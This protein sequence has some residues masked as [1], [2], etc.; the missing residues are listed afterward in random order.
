VT[1]LF[2]SILASG[3]IPSSY[4]RATIIPLPKP[5]S[6]EFRPISLL[7]HLSKVLEKIVLAKW[8]RPYVACNIKHDQFAFTSLNGTGCPN[9]L[10]V[11]Y[12]AALQST[13][14]PGDS[15]RILAID[16]VKAFDRAASQ[17]LM[18]ALVRLG[19]PQECYLWIRNF[20]QHR[21]QRVR[22]NNSF[23]A[24]LPVRSGVPQGS[25]T[26]P[27]LFAALIDS[28]SPCLSKTTCIKYADDVTMVHHIPKGEIDQ[29]DQEW[30]AVIAWAEQHD[31]EI[32]TKKTKVMTISFSKTLL[33]QLASLQG[34]DA[35]VV[36]QV[37]SMK[38]LGLWITN[39]LKWNEQVLSSIKRSNKGIFLLRQLKHG[40]I[41][42]NVLWMIYNALIRSHLTYASPATTN[43]PKTLFQ[44]LEKVEKRV[45]KI[46]GG[47]PPLSLNEFKHQICM[48]VLVDAK[49]ATSHPLRQLFIL[50][51]SSHASKHYQHFRAPYARTNRFR[52]SFI[53]YAAYS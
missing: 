38:L 21:E 35:T 36:E 42:N 50:N 23:S 22:V 9:A 47:T 37:P 40:G 41:A 24:W 34:S 16:F 6:K 52:D 15:A 48:N 26:G 12:N 43:M 45:S 13:E 18:S 25:V 39:D 11:I 5:G 2:N 27:F 44:K 46:I 17:H 49:C 51:T 31:L 19:V 1:Q 53:S 4:K 10:T 3:V 30:D 32:N 33:P 28:L 7:P 29:L 20:L 14:N 8:L